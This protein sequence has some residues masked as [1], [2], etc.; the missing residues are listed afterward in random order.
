ME[1]DTIIVGGTIVDGTGKREPY[2]ADVG[3]QGDRIAEIGDL[4][5]AET[6]NRISAEDKLYVLVL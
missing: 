2:I 1:F 3:I 6:P 4:N 5:K